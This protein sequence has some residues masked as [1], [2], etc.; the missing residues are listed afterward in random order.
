MSKEQKDLEIK[1]N[2]LGKELGDNEV[3]AASGGSFCF[4]EL[5][6][7]GSEDD[8]GKGNDDF[9]GCAIAGMGA[10]KDLYMR[11]ACPV[12]GAGLDT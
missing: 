3:E 8:P 11:C 4:C 6:G 5:V 7:Y 10:D 2:E 12:A 1:A 9:C